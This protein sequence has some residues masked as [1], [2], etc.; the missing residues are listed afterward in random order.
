MTNKP[1]STVVSRTSYQGAAYTHQGWVL[2]TKWQQ[3]LLL[4][5]EYD[6]YDRVDPA[7]DGYHVTYIW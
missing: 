4:D 5:D 2:D 6:E 3:F 1:N 7:A